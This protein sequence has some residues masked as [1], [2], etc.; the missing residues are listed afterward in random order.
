MPQ[1][2]L[3]TKTAIPNTFQN[4]SFECASYQR[5]NYPLL[6]ADNWSYHRI[7]IGQTKTKI[8]M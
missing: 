2:V 7:Q 3:K 6:L 1:T 5:W 4:L 8:V